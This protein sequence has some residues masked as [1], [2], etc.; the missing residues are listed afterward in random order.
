MYFMHPMVTSI[1]LGSFNCVWLDQ[2][3]KLE[4]GSMRHAL[5][6]KIDCESPEH[7]SWLWIAGFG[8]V[9]WSLGI[10]LTYWLKLRR[11]VRSPTKSLHDF[12]SMRKFGFLYD[13]FE[14]DQ[15]YYETIFMIRKAVVLMVATFPWLLDQ[16]RTVLLLAM[17]C[18]FLSMDLRDEPFDNRAYFGLDRLQKW[19]SITII[20]I[21]LGRLLEQALLSIPGQILEDKTAIAY[22]PALVSLVYF[23]SQAIY[24]LLRSLIWPLDGECP[25]LPSQLQFLDHRLVFTMIPD[26]NLDGAKEHSLLGVT[27]GAWRSVASH[28][29]RKLNPRE[30]ELLR[31]TLTEALE[32]ILRRHEICVGRAPA[33]ICLPSLLLQLE[34]VM[35]VCMAGAIRAR[36]RA[37]YKTINRDTWWKYLKGIGQDTLSY[38]ED[39]LH[40]RSVTL[41]EE[42]TKHFDWSNRTCSALCRE[43]DSIQKPVSVEEL[44]VALMNITPPLL[45]VQRNAT[46]NELRRIALENKGILDMSSA[47]SWI[48]EKEAHLGR[49]VQYN[50]E[51]GEDS[52][53]SATMELL[54]DRDGSGLQQDL[55]RVEVWED[56]LG[57]TQSSNWEKPVDWVQQTEEEFP[58]LAGIVG[59][60]SLGPYSAC[61]DLWNL[62]VAS[63][64]QLALAAE[65]ANPAGSRES[66]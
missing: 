12:D 63:T 8:V 6:M 5:N 29:L 21:L 4:Y 59:N 45:D 35:V 60:R 42:G 65:P 13:G 18:A 43:A 17:T 37:K 24:L 28:Q 19:S 23:L 53:V 34:R 36:I 56:P 51:D 62:S 26:S 44:H 1:F 54:E 48:F 2:E 3:T 10:P 11:I 58:E 14:P 47:T 64:E 7:E 20:V 57:D 46:G 52:E 49:L 25:L 38:A 30:R 31:S 50:V 41:N 16:A 55:P 9:F 15:Y 27:S 40:A 22:L 61:R 39:L 66:I 32:L 33:I